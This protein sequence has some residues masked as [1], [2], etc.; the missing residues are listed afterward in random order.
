M[1]NTIALFL[2]IFEQMLITSRICYFFCRF[3]IISTLD[4][5]SVFDRNAGFNVA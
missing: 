4:G 2:T 3:K 1:I 5:Q